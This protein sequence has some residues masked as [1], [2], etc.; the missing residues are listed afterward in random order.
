MKLHVGQ[1]KTQEA[2]TEA[3]DEMTLAEQLGQDVLES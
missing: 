2:I 1:D 3:E